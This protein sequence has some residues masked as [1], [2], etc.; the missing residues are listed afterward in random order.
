MEGVKA[1]FEINGKPP[2]KRRKNAKIKRKNP[3]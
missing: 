1:Q 3:L 2:V